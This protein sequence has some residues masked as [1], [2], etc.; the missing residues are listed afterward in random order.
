MKNS[1]YTTKICI[2]MCIISLSCYADPVPQIDEAYFKRNDLLS[3]SYLHLGA[4]GT[5]KVLKDGDVYSQ[6]IDSGAW[7]Q[8]GNGDI[9][10]HSQATIRNI[11]SGPL[12][13]QVKDVLNA[14][15]ILPRLGVAVSAFLSSNDTATTF[16]REEIEGIFQLNYRSVDNPFCLPAIG[17]RLAV[18]TVPRDDL[19]QLLS[20]IQPY[21]DDDE[22]NVIRFSMRQTGGL[23]VL[24]RPDSPYSSDYRLENIAE[25]MNQSDSD[26]SK[27][28][29]Y[30]EIDS[31]QYQAD[32][33]PIQGQIIPGVTGE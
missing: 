19:T 27:N 32:V 8:E 13:I 23:T 12:I 21:M 29:F 2:L 17:V 11:V 9:L 25:I 14:E 24:V 18:N 5:Y 26:E 20:S 3:A 30:Y 28:G 33:A 4:D 31:S 7:Q 6:I 15:N 22:K 16:T 10:L 1:S